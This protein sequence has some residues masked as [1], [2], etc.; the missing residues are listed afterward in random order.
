[1]PCQIFGGGD[2]GFIAIGA[3]WFLSTYIAGTGS[4]DTM[5]ETPN[6]ERLVSED[7]GFFSW[8]HATVLLKFTLGSRK[9]SVLIIY[10]IP[11]ALLTTLSALRLLGPESQP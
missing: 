9:A 10:Q 6:P 1:M 4:T 11:A 2:G 5:P 7:F 8:A 3:I